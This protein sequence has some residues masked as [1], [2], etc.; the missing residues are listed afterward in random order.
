MKK[1]RQ[2]AAI[3]LREPLYRGKR[4]LRIAL[5]G[6]PNSGKSTLFNAVS[7]TSI[8]TG[9]LGGTRRAYNECAVQIGLDEARVVETA[10][11]IHL[12]NHQR[13]LLV[14]PQDL[15]IDGHEVK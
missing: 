14:Q 11:A 8:R 3:P 9:E 2:V 15:V 12:P 7:S 5:V 10:K 13:L 4:R 1:A 6:M